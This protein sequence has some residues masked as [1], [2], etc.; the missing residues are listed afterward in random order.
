VYYADVPVG[1]VTCRLEPALSAPPTTA[2]KLHVLTLNVLPPYRSQGLGAHLLDHVLTKAAEW[3][4]PDVLGGKTRAASK[5][6]EKEQART[7]DKVMVY[8]QV[9]NEE[10]KSFYVKKAGFVEKETSV[11]CPFAIPSSR[12][13]HLTCRALCLTAASRTTTTRSSLGLR[14]CLSA[15]PRLL[16]VMGSSLVLAAPTRSSR[17]RERT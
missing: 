8:C 13:S 12:S 17:C 7:V 10:A 5:E 2:L 15:S 14:S 6:K 4:P 11:G 1:S 9:G 3:T 16:D